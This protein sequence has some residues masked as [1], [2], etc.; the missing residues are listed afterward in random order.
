MKIKNPNFILK[1]ASQ[2]RCVEVKLGEWRRIPAAFV[3]NWILIVIMRFINNGNIRT[4][5][6][7]STKN[8]N[9]KIQ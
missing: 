8:E 6:K 1:L 9:T 5:K 4:Y 3:Q 2:G 7:E